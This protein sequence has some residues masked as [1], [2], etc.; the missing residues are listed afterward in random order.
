[1]LMSCWELVCHV[2]VL[3][4]IS[5][6]CWELLHFVGLWSTRRQCI[7]SVL[8]GVSSSVYPA[9]HPYHL[10]AGGSHLSP[11]CLDS[12]CY[13][14]PAGICVPHV[15]LV[16]VSPFSPALP[17][18]SAVHA[19]CSSGQ[20]SGILLGGGA[21]HVCKGSAYSFPALPH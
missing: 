1:M 3:L 4:G 8:L 17:E 10:G 12:A 7:T 11:V 16:C 20:V 14:C 13:M 5:E 21:S 15:P 19:D 6:S 2:M 18:V 9:G